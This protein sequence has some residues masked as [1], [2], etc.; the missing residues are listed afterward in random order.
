MRRKLQLKTPLAHGLPP[1][2]PVHGLLDRIPTYFQENS[3]KHF[4]MRVETPFPTLSLT[5]QKP[6]MKQGDVSKQSRFL[7]QRRFLFQRQLF[8]RN[9]T[10]LSNTSLLT[11]CRCHRALGWEFRGRF[12]GNLRLLL[13][14]SKP[15]AARL[16]NVPCEEKGE[17]SQTRLRERSNFHSGTWH[18]LAPPPAPPQYFKLPQKIARALRRVFVVLN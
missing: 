16:R 10:F 9:D 4:P 3:L 5:K 12:G 13:P 15:T 18:R 8:S 7:P 1:K 11:N 17:L 14:S 2:H 6:K